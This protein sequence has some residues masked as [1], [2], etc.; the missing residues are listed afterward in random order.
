MLRLS[1]IDNSK[2]VQ[3]IMKR[4]IMIIVHMLKHKTLG[5]SG[6]HWWNNGTINKM[7]K[8]CPLGFSKG[9]LPI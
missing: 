6:M 1:V 2:N 5:S 9:K 8:D 4:I 7:S 3:R